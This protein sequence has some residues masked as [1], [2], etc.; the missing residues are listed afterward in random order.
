MDTVL[1]VLV[2]ILIVAVELLLVVAI[3]APQA[4]VRAFHRL[5]PKTTSAGR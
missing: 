2:C 4:I 1:L 5:G 3:F